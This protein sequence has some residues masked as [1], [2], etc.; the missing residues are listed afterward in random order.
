VVECGASLVR[1]PHRS[2]LY[3]HHDVYRQLLRLFQRQRQPGDVG[4]VAELLSSAIAVCHLYYPHDD[5][6][7]GAYG[8]R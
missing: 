1:R 6:S 2:G 5:A 3:R 4:D 7:R 8:Q